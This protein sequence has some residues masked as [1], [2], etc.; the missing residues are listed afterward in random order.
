MAKTVVYYNYMTY[1]L[2]NVI[3]D[4]QL[5][6]DVRIRH[7]ACAPVKCGFYLQQHPHFTTLKIRIFAH[8]HFTRGPSL[9]RPG[10]GWSLANIRINFSSSETKMIFLPNAENRTIVSS[11]IWTKHRNMTDGQTDSQTESF[12]LLQQSALRATDFFPR[13]VIVEYAN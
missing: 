9:K 3:G 2:R 4:W 1:K 7:T 13:N 12:W 11:L 5:H 10:K 6:A 8:P